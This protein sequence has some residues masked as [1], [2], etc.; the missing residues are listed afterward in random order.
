M[1][2]SLAL[3]NFAANMKLQSSYIH[4]RNLRFHARHGV[5]SQEREVGADFT[6]T[7]RIGFD[8]SQAMQ[9]DNVADTLNYAYI[10]NNVRASMAEPSQLLEHAAGRIAH[11]LFDSFPRIQ[12][13][14]LELTKCNPPMGA[15]SDGAGVEL[16]LINDKTF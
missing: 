5:A 12:S 14:D 9:T 1:S 7:L 10:Y 2:K 3:T 6:V 11:N 8:I 15:D 13:L 4:L 16:H